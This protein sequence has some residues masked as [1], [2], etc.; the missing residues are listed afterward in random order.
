MHSR[1]FVSPSGSEQ[2]YLKQ[3]EEIQ[4]RDNVIS[5]QKDLN[6]R[7][8]TENQQLK[9]QKHQSPKTVVAK[10]SPPKMVYKE[11]SN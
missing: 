4:W 10:I 2:Q 6:H 9:E 11:S 1:L 5:T 7:M 3:K 8:H